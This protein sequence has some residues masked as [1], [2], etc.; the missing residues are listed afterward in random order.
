MMESNYQKYVSVF[1]QAKIALK[2]AA[3]LIQQRRRPLRHELGNTPQSVFIFWTPIEPGSG[4]IR[5][6]SDVPFDAIKSRWLH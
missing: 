1:G 4:Q 2:I 5:Q 3:H 6:V